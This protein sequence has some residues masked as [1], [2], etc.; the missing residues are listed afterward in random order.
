MDDGGFLEK[1]LGDYA[2]ND[3]DWARVP[4]LL[5]AESRRIHGKG[6][7]AIT[8]PWYSLRLPA[9]QGVTASLVSISGARS[10]T[11]TSLAYLPSNKLKH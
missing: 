6:Q 2:S 11:D 7:L 4:T 5:N 1:C 8:D 10:G 9:R 3:A